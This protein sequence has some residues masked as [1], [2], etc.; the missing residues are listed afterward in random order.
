M[1]LYSRYF[2]VP[3]AL[4]LIPISGR[5]EGKTISAPIKFESREAYDSEAQARIA[6]FQL[7]EGVKATL[8]ADSSQTQNPSAICFD[9][10]GRL[11]VAEIH[12]WRAGVQDI[13]D[14]PRLL[15]DDLACQTTADRLAMYEKDQAMRPLSFYTEFTDRIM[16]LEDRDHD[17][18]ADHSTLFADGFD[19]VLDGPGIGLI[20]DEAGAVY[21]TNIP[22]LWKLLDKDGKGVA[23]ERISLQDGFGVR[24][25]IS[26]HDMHG[27]VWGPDGKLYWSIGDRGYSFIT[28]EGRSYHHPTSGAVF[29][30]DP[31][32]SNLEEIYTG[33]RNPQELA[34]DAWG[35]L[36]T[37][38]NNADA[39]DSGRLV[40]ILEG[41]DS[42]WRHGHQVMLNFRDTL[43]LRTPDYTHPGHKTIPLNAWMAEGLWETEHP[44]RPDFALPPVAELSWGPSG[45]VYNYGVTTMPQ[46][47]TDH[48]WVCNFGGAKGDL[49]TFSVQE[50]GAGFT[51]KDQETFMVGMGNTDAEFGPDGKLYVSCFNN[52]GWVKQD[53]GN[54]YTLE[55]TPST[56]GA[57]LLRATQS[58]LV[59]SFSKY[60]LGK[61]DELLGH[62]DMRV[63]QRAQFELAR[64]QASEIFTDAV[65]Q[66]ENRFKRL[67]GLWGLGQL[68]REKPDLLQTHIDSLSDPDIEVRVQAAKILGDSREASAGEALVPALDDSSPRVRAFAAIGV[69]K[70]GNHMALSKLFE[71]LAANDDQDLFLRHACVQG[72]WY[73]HDSERMMKEGRINPAPAVRLGVLL[74]L[75]KLLD[76]RVKYFLTDEVSR[77]R[78]EAIRAIHDLD[79][80]T[81][82]PDLAEELLSPRNESEESRQ[83][84]NP[85][86][87]MLQ[88][89][90]INANFRVGTPK[91]AQNLL[92]FAA[93][94]NRSLLLREQA[95]R[96]LLEWKAPGPVDAV[97]GDYRPLPPE[98]RADI[99]PQLT[100]G[101]SPIFQSSE[102]SLVGLAA[103]VAMAYGI[104]APAP[105][106]STL[107]LDS[108]APVDAR[109]AAL[110]SLS[111]DSP[112]ELDSHWPTLLQ[113]KN[114]E[115][116]AAAITA[117]ARHDVA[118]GS[119]AA[120]EMAK[121]KDLR[122]RQR[123]YHLL[124]TL[125]TPETTSFL[126]NRLAKISAEPLDSR[127]D[128][129]E[130]AAARGGD[131]LAKQIVEYEKSLDPNDPVA[132]FQVTLKGGDPASGKRIFTSHAVGQ[133]TKC[134]KIDG[135][136]GTAGPDLSSVGAQRDR[137]FLLRALITPSAEI[138][139]GYGITLVTFKDG[140]SIGGV[141]TK[142]T[143]T[144]I[145]LKI[146]DPATTDLHRE[147]A[148]PLKEIQKREP[149]VSAMPPMGVLLKKTEIRDLI[150]YLA[151]LRKGGAKKVQ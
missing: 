31:D 102:K 89:R 21:Y 7:P 55:G 10:Q 53:I 78:N 132:P 59:Q 65:Q 107:L 137:D 74:T 77:I 146:A 136:G 111:T 81:A 54:I 105:I 82:L 80:L 26:G 11:L 14:E 147:Q 151:T 50:K 149:A 38:D 79:F 116:R 58:L 62:A 83:A 37:C 138:A 87:L 67:H 85:Q 60:D 134:H 139:E 129:I 61:L 127:L 135:D 90:L 4:S 145:V 124:A 115:L 17:G 23:N 106:L 97:T 91:C 32:G 118:Q 123:A 45:L 52:N 84:S 113:E 131:A 126:S 2:L 112:S 6:N 73:L 36:F 30:C 121:S 140:T 101:L 27:L 95:L 144:E 29:R 94:E 56:E 66:T 35:N 1:S 57:A 109:I 25:S 141:L 40:Y 19:S 148:I 9:P 24:I 142:E 119:T 75:R 86:E 125:N 18:R 76:P 12:R 110:E 88:M 68:A 128:L 22:H 143:P 71:Q 51:V 100:A 130:S 34:F 64:R 8:F 104:P 98:S 13:R 3:I 46:R 70:C 92:T 5:S 20:T 48:F 41:G 150:A 133:C 15:L 117:L 49:Q 44:G 99:K 47:Y 122:L 114:P 103:R 16:R 28:K 96:T 39:W 108:A 93:Q 120:I 33:L 63:R 69:G 43:Q 72:M 42:G